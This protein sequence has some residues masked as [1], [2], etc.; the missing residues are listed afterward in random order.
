MFGIAGFGG[1]SGGFDDPELSGVTTSLVGFGV[2]VAEKEEMVGVGVGGDSGFV[3][4]F[5]LERGTGTGRSPVLDALALF[6]SI[7]AARIL[8]AVAGI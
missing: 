5:S 3:V 7:S 6:C 4:E 8:A 1:G 2:E